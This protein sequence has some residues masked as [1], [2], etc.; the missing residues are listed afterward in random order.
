MRSQPSQADQEKDA[1]I[2]HLKGKLGSIK[3]E[4]PDDATVRADV[5][6]TAGVE[7]AV[8][9]N[10]GATPAS[11]AGNAWDAISGIMGTSWTSGSNRT[12]LDRCIRVL[13]TVAHNPEKCAELIEDDTTRRAL[14]IAIA[15]VRERHAIF[16][17]GDL[18]AIGDPRV[19]ALNLMDYG[20]DAADKVDLSLRRILDGG[21]S[22]EHNAQ[23]A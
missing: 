18:K 7:V 11:L 19:G 16:V 2:R 13:E 8:S 1:L 5:S 15:D 22:S 14:K 9:L 4:R 6:R 20:E 12:L 23:S 17:T 10:D 3:S 21:V